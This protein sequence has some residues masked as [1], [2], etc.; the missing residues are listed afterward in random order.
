MLVA[1]P[2]EAPGGLD[3]VVSEHF[4]HCDVFT[5][6]QINDGELGE[7]TVL[8]N[9]PHENGGC[10]AP[11]MFLKQ[12]SIDALVAGGMGGRPL[13]GFQKEG[14]KVFFKEEADTVRGAVDLVVKGEARVFGEAQT[15]SG[16]GC[17]GHEH[18]VVERDPIEGTAD[19]R[20]GRVVSF[21]YTLTEKGGEQLDTSGNDRP[22][23]YLHGH[24]NIVPG[25]EQA[26]VGLVA[27]DHKVVE[28]SAAAGYGKRDESKIK[29]MPRDKLPP[30]PRVG[31]MMHAR[32]ANGEV[33]GITVV[34]VLDDSVRVDFNHPLA[35]KD[36]IFDVT[37]V[38]VE[39]ATAE[40]LAH[41]QVH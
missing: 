26:L 4:G 22:L 19:I 28:V 33:I 35:G 10:M 41:R 14:I 20:D 2:S 6:V 11:V 21:H 25:L 9:I 31:A 27:G 12:S 5:L 1:V 15:C 30:N 24:G 18:H 17:G 3:A 36:L 32:Q 16:G 39:S 37:I 29:E 38:K 8:E 34:E 13:A 40:E 7:V 23:T